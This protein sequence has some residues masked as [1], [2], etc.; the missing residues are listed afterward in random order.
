MTKIATS[1]N[2]YTL[3]LGEKFKYFKFGDTAAKIKYKISRSYDDT[4][5]NKVYTFSLNQTAILPTKHMLI[6]THQTDLTKYDTTESSNT[7]TYLV[8]FDYMVPEII[9]TYTLGLGLSSTF[10]PTLVEATTPKRG[11]EVTWNPSV[12]ITKKTTKTLSTTI[13]Y[14]YTKKTSGNK[15][16]YAYSKQVTSIDL[17]YSF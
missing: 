5:H 14:N 16:S 13:S 6:F 8:R 7:N 15:A 9:P 4:Q 3:S 10:S 11:L 1:S 2:G 12:K 17:A